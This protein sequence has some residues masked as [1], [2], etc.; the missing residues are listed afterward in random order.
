MLPENG[1]YGTCMY[2]ILTVGTLVCTLL[3]F[4]FFTYSVALL[5]KSISLVFYVM[6]QSYL[7]LKIKHH[8][9][10]LFVREVRYEVGQQLYLRSPEEERDNG[11]EAV[12][13]MLRKNL[14]AGP[15]VVTNI[16][17]TPSS[18][19]APQMVQIS[20]QKKPSVWISTYWFTE[21]K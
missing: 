13:Q 21:S 18:V 4:K 5:S 11:N 12:L 3:K 16:T 2:V 20:I 19:L 8:M 10:R 14:G 17:D 6:R 15:F 1:G 9:L 7:P